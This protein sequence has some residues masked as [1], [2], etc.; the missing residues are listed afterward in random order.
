MAE[1]V[2]TRK[3]M[4][5]NNQKYFNGSGAGP[6]NITQYFPAGTVVSPKN[7]S[8][9]PPVG[10]MA[11]INNVVSQYFLLASVASPKC[12]LMIFDLKPAP[13]AWYFVLRCIYTTHNCVKPRGH[14]QW[15][16]IARMQTLCAV[17]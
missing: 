14:F 6:K 1:H 8:Q 11:S 16:E 5:Y 9:Y 2:Q 15:L 10:N 12:F 4:S 3:N 17:P 7:I 13:R